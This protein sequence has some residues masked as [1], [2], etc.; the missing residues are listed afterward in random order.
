MARPSGSDQAPNSEHDTHVLS[1]SLV[2][3]AHVTVRQRRNAQIEPDESANGGYW[4]HVRIR[5]SGTEIEV[6]RE[7]RW[8]ISEPDA[9]K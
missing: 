1:A 6:T 9:K 8:G 4:F 2:L 5:G 3:H 7:W